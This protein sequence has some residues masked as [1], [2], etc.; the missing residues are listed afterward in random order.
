[1]VT[2]VATRPLVRRRHGVTTAA[3]LP[4]LFLALMLL[5]SSCSTDG[6]APPTESA[7]DRTASDLADLDVEPGVSECVIRLAGGQLDDPA[8]EPL[9]SAALGELVETCVDLGTASDAAA[10]AD[11][12]SDQTVDPSR[13]S[14]P[15]AGPHTNGDDPELDRLWSRC[16]SGS[17]AACDELFEQAPVASDYERFGLTCG[18]RELVLHCAE[19]DGAEDS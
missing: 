15:P 12:A 19:L 6:S 14:P 17:G 3:R 10:A 8:A 7:K 13:S 1:M 11:S 2:H 18:S 5:S 4:V 16:E 9:G